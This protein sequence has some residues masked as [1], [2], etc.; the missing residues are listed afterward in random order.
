LRTA[1][2][3]AKAWADSGLAPSTVAVNV[4]AR[5]FLRQD[6]VSWVMDALER[7]GLAPH[8]LELELTESVIAEDPEKVAATIRELKQHGV[9]FSI[10]DF[11]TG[12]SSLSY[13]KRFPVD[14]LKIDQSF[15]KNV[16]TAA[17][18]EAISLAV[19]SLAHTLRLKVIAEGVETAQQREFLERHGCDEIQGFHYS[20]PLPPREF[21]TL[22]ARA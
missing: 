9:K 11:G 5:Q 14:A 6:V 13:L 7:T 15:V 3:Q 22:L 12:Y 4:S 1:C 21:E 17:D 16:G 8:L 2:S 18:D 10:D 20:P 19:I